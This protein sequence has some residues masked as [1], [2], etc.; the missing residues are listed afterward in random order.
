MLIGRD[1]ERA[2]IGA[3]L[4]AARASRSDALVVRGAPGMGK[5]ALLDDTREAATDMH[6]L[7]ARGVESESDLPFAGLHQMVRPAMHLLDALP[8]P[9]A[10]ALQ[11]ALGLSE[12]SG[13]DRFLISVAC[14]SLLS[15][16]AEQKPVL[17]LVDDVQWLDTPS[18]DTLLFVARRLDAEGIL[19]LF[20]LREA[21]A[22]RFDPRDLRNLE[23]TKL[24]SESSALLLA[25]GVEGEVAPSVRA[26]L[27]EHAA[28]NPLALMELPKALTGD[29]LAGEEP[30][31]YTLPL[32]S[33]VERLFLVQVRELPEQARRLLLVVAA[34]H[35]GRI[36]PVLEAAQA[37]SIPPNALDL[38]QTTGLAFVRG[39]GI[40]LRHPLVGSAV[41]QA[42]PLTERQATHLALAAALPNDAEADQR[43]WHRA[44]AAVGPSSEIA[45]ELERT[46]TRAR[47]RSGY[48]AAAAALARAAELSPDPDSKARRL[49]RAATAAWRSGRPD[50]ASTLIERAAPLVSNAEQRAEVAHL[51]GVIGFWCGDLLEA[52]E[53][54]TA[55]VS[56]ARGLGVR[57]SLDM[58]VD[59]AEA[60][61]WAGDFSRVRR[62]SELV[63]SLPASAS[64][65]DTMLADLL[66]SVTGLFS[67]R[68]ADELPQVA[69]IL[70]SAEGF[71]EPRWLVWAAAAAGA[72]GDRGRETALLR[73][74]GRLARASGAADTL[75]HVLVTVAA[76]GVFEGRVE[77]IVSATEG[78]TLARETRLSNAASMHLAVLAWFA[79]IKGED[80]CCREMA[81]EVNDIARITSNGFANALANWGV[82]LLDLGRGRAQEAVARL[83]LVAESQPGESQPFVALASAPDLVEAYVRAGKTEEAAAA[84]AV[85]EGFAQAGAPAW[86]LALAARCKALL[87]S[88][89]AEAEHEFEE[90]LRLH[91]EDN[92]A[93]DRARTAL[94]YGE[95]LRRGRRR[96][97][98]REHLRA[99]VA[100]FEQLG[101]QPWA[102]R[103]RTELRASG[104]TARKRDP[105][106]IDLLTPQ[107]LQIARLVAEG[108]S[109]K[110]VA[111]QL[112]LSPRT[113]HY[114]LRHVFVKLDITSRTQLAL[115]AL[116][117]GGEV[118]AASTSAASPG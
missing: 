86:S 88:D 1:V 68:S 37:L 64:A 39:P 24:D 53:L 25:R 74:A 41:Y 50:Q 69:G 73:Q 29:Q 28:G 13:A 31:P 97:E 66:S 45:D 26:A 75:A 58:L 44:A 113:I 92:R 81:L 89:S 67:G 106:T 38:L 87:E 118:T 2:A 46:A 55:C 102:E 112:F 22:T 63:A 82:A 17:C 27:V 78:L 90:A 47:L 99:A 11:G 95:H 54:L 30:F 5:T 16:L 20:A 32:T 111:A 34:D 21:D 15:E 51:Q 57:R 100:A 65:E 40:E 91:S 35:T 14:L 12:R 72:I 7:S 33:S 114:H 3:L 42:A 70:D 104:E 48:A 101:A 109:N 85:V 84:F 60:A 59:A 49:I 76:R 83:R 6:V 56:N 110:E 107:E 19:M 103:A 23:L 61:A 10:D 116:A 36:A 108:L 93:F 62:I 4:E 98:S 94:L 105:S 43:A 79:A 117:E 96:V 71:E 8:R 115:F 9:Q 77:A 52:S 18:A 80:E